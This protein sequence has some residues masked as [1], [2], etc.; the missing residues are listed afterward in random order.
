MADTVS[1]QV[2]T[3]GPRTYAVR[4]TNISDGTGESLVQKV[5][6]SALLAPSGVAAT[7]TNIQEI[8]WSI[9]GFS[10]VALY[11]DH[12]TDSIIDILAEGN[13]YR[14]YVWLGGLADPQPGVATGDILLTTIGPA[15]D[16]TYD[17]TLVLL[18]SN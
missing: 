9:R 14:D 17:I 1:T 18:L 6:I 3:T 11:W 16:A 13:G 4:L 12:A 15:V 5:D 8:Q 7:S 10:S 2:I